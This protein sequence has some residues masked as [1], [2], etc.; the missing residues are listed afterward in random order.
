MAIQPQA[1]RSLRREKVRTPGGRLVMHYSKRKPDSA[2]CGNCR[3]DLKGIPRASSAVLRNLP[4]SQRTVSRPYGGNLCSKCSRSKIVGK[5]KDIKEVPLEIGQICI[6]TCGREAG[7]ICVVIERLDSHFVLIDGQVRRRKCNI[8]HLKTLDNKI[9]I[10]KGESSEN[11]K[12]EFK[13][14][15]YE[16]KEKKVKDKKP[17]ES[18]KPKKGTKEKKEKDAKRTS[19]KIR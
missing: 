12:K 16:I 9:D 10:K 13:K 14:L 18:E 7:Q 6:K 2:K 5:F 17:V 11:I 8:F 1:T 3:V 19:K 4:L 15:G